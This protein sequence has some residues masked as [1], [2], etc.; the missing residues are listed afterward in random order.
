MSDSTYSESEVSAEEMALFYQQASDY[1]E[2]VFS[3]VRQK[4]PFDIEAGV[5]IVQKM[6][7]IPPPMTM[8]C[9]SRRFKRTI[10]LPF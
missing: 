9:L 1:L 5:D 8:H 2:K 6:I 3:A 10:R 7:E 4:E